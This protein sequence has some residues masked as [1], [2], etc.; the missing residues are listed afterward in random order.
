[1]GLI[2]GVADF[3]IVTSSKTIFVELKTEKGRQ[4]DFQKLFQ[5]W[6]E[7]MI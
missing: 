4:S 5:K 2:N 6:C 3:V 7:K 1:M